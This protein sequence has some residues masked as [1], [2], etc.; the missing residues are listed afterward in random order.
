M[1]GVVELKVP[2]GDSC[3]GAVRSGE[4][5]AKDV[6]GKGLAPVT[7]RNQSQR[8]KIAYSDCEYHQRQSGEKSVPFSLLCSCYLVLVS[9]VASCRCAIVFSSSRTA[10]THLILFDPVPP[11]ARDPPNSDYHDSFLVLPPTT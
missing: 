7:A 5:A 10:C 2:T 4:M 3:A 8:G 1:K 6:P 11:T 9:R